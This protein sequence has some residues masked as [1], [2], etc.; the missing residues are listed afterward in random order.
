[1]RILRI[2]GLAK[3]RFGLLLVVGG[4]AIFFWYYAINITMVIGLLPVVGIPLPFFSYGGT[5]MVV[6]FMILGVIMN[7]YARRFVY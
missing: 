6:N 3:N 4:G 5:A 1:M 2:A 7:V